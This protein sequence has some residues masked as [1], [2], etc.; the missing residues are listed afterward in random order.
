MAL[1]DERC[2]AFVLLS[3]AQEECHVSGVRLYRKAEMQPSRFA[4]QAG[5]V[6]SDEDEWLDG[7]NQE[8]P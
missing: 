8:N 4:R 6:P 7:E 3:R 2:V 1:S 5:L